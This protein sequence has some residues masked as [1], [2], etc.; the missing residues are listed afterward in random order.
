M[1]TEGSASESSA[2]SCFSLRLD[3]GVWRYWFICTRLVL[4]VKLSLIIAMFSRG[5]WRSHGLVAEVVAFSNRP[6]AQSQL[7]LNRGD[8]KL[9]GG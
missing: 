3:G 9:T 8:C 2:D 4:S 5:F 1:D 7:F 6:L